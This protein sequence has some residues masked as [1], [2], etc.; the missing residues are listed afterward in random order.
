MFPQGFIDYMVEH[1][2]WRDCGCEGG[3]TYLAEPS[4][5]LCWACTQGGCVPHCESSPCRTGCPSKDH[6]TWGECARAAAIQIDR[7]ALAAA[8]T[9]TKRASA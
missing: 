4:S 9:D 6:A 8:R 1:G 7:A 3:C 5:R 2:P